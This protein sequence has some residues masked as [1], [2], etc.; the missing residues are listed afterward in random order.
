MKT[1]QC[2]SCCLVLTKTLYLE[3]FLIAWCIWLQS[4]GFIQICSIFHKKYLLNFVFTSMNVWNEILLNEMNKIFSWKFSWERF[5]KYLWT[6]TFDHTLHNLGIAVF[7]Q[8]PLHR[9]WTFLLRISSVSLTKS[10]VS[11]TKSSGNW[12]FDHIYWRN[13]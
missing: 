12:W 4:I 6:A 5:Y 9:K 2:C 1:W 13:L 8:K 10:S 11:L 7:F 3:Q